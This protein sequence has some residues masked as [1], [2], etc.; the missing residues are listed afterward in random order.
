MKRLSNVQ[1][2]T[3]YMEANA[4]NQVIVLLALDYYT[5]RVVDNEEKFLEE[6]LKTKNDGM[7]DGNAYVTACKTWRSNHKVTVG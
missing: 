3:N 1:N 2:V 6:F 5:Q 7:F 4:M